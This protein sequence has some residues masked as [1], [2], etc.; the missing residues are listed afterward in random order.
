LTQNGPGQDFDVLM[1]DGPGLDFDILFLSG[2]I[3]GE[4]R[5]RKAKDLKKLQLL[6]KDKKFDNF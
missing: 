3:L 4:P 1:R 5:D 2:N 6:K